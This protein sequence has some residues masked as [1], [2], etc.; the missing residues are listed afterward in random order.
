MHLSGDAVAQG[1]AIHARQRGVG[2]T[3]GKEC[4]I[5]CKAHA[6]AQVPA[7]PDPTRGALWNGR[8]LRGVAPAVCVCVCPQH[9]QQ[10]KGMLLT[11][12]QA[13]RHAL[14]TTPGFYTKNPQ[15]APGAQACTN[16]FWVDNQ[17]SSPHNVVC[18]QKIMH[19]ALDVLTKVHG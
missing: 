3:R 10:T 6:V 15:T 17:W 14:I 8:A 11:A 1:A 4:C 16:L 7:W 12:I 5:S 2:N 13:G 9:C 19:R 18:T